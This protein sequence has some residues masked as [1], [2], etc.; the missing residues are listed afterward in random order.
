[1]IVL[2]RWRGRRLEVS[3]L[4]RSHSPGSLK[5]VYTWEDLGEGGVTVTGD[6]ESA[7]YTCFDIPDVAFVVH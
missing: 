7:L 1:M 3:V 5:V 2:T 4:Q 6:D